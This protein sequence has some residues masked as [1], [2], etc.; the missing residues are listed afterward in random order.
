LWVPADWKLT[1]KCKMTR[2]CLK[3][4]VWDEKKHARNVFAESSVYGHFDHLAAL[5]YL[6]RCIDT[7][8]NPIPAEYGISPYT[9]LYIIL[10]MQT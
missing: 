6:I 9:H 1:L 5:V 8:T 10:K 2:G 7:V 3:Y 4:G